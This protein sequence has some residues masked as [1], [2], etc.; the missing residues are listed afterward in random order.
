MAFLAVLIAIF[1]F[2]LS[3]NGTKEKAWQ[4]MKSDLTVENAERKQKNELRLYD[5]LYD[6]YQVGQDEAIVPSQLDLNELEQVL[7]SND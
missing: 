7:Y 6:L 3:L 1:R 4:L 2:L 5:R